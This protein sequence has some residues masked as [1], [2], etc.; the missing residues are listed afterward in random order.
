MI[1][2]FE[3]DQEA[4]LVT[5]LCKGGDLQMYMEARDFK[6]LPESRLKHIAKGIASGLKFLHENST[7]HRDIKPENILL[8][9]GSES[10][11]SVIA[12]FGC[13]TMLREGQVATGLFGTRGY[14]APE[15]LLG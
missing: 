8:S 7:I 4:F 12:D 2:F 6:D 9:N 15:I 5:R 11:D 13:S 3:N 10:S 1:E 14:I